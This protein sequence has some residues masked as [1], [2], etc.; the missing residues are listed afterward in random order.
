M[1]TITEIKVNVVSCKQVR[2]VVFAGYSEALTMGHFT[3]VCSVL[4]LLNRGEAGGDFVFLQ[5]LLLFTSKS[6]YSH[7]NKPVNMITYIR[8]TRF[9]TEQGHRQPRFNSKARALSTQLQN[10]L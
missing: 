4:W 10:S 8:K 5:T 1:K 2:S 7:A 3:V 6:W 9:V